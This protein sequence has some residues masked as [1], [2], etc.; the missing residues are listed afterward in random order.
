MIK[1]SLDSIGQLVLVSND[2]HTLLGVLYTQR[3][4]DIAEAHAPNGFQC[5]Q[6]AFDPNGV[7]WVSIFVYLLLEALFID[8]FVF[9]SN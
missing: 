4:H 7:V 5:I 6:D 1:L 8:H 9:F 3:L 2:D